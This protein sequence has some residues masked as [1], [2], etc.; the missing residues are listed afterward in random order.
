[1]D[2]VPWSWRSISGTKGLT[3]GVGILRGSRREFDQEGTLCVRIWGEEDAKHV[4]LKCSETNNCREEFVR[5]K[6]LFY[7]VYFFLISFRPLFFMLHPRLGLS[8]HFFP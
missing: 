1:M 5:N 7:S 2:S 4:S 8:R 6:R 3:A